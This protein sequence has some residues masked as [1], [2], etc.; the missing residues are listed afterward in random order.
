MNAER[1]FA[2][3]RPCGI[4]FALPPAIFRRLLLL[5]ALYLGN[6]ELALV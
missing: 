3:A 6:A 4:P 5:V 1:N 2:D